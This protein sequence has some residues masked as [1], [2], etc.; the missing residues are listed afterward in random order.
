MSAVNLLFL[1]G[2]MLLV[3][4]VTLVMVLSVAFWAVKKLNLIFE[5]KK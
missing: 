4:L 2:L 5:E 1:V 3:G